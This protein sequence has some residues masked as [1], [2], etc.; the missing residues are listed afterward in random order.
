MTLL[1]RDFFNRNPLEV[2]PELLGKI[3]VRKVENNIIS[4]RIVE[5]EAYLGFIDEAAH[6]FIGK[7]K[8]N[9]SLFGEPGCAYVH[10]IHMQHC[11]DVVTCEVDDPGS[12]LIRALEPIEGIEI[13]KIFRDKDNL[14]DL[15]NGPGKLCQAL[16]ITKSLDGIDMKDSS[17][18][19][20]LIDD[21][22]KSGKIK[23][24]KR[25]GISKAKE[26]EW[27]VYIE[28]NNFISKK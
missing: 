13:M 20:Y 22:Y 18:E 14:K 19:L 8:R 16:N 23:K 15:T 4:G 6:S 28:N 10:R 1:K 11:L 5:V 2:A 9:N 3:L 24:S 7:T 26:H 27:R 21:G 17:S 25:I 12:V